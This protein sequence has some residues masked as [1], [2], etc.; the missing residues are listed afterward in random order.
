MFVVD[1]IFDGLVSATF[2]SLLLFPLPREKREKEKRKK[3]KPKKRINKKI[4]KE[5]Y[6]LYLILS[7]P[8]AYGELYYFPSKVRV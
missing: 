2:P 3:K 1:V 4:K 6:H 8:P 5:I 7:Y